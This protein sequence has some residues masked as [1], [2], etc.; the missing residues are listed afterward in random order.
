MNLKLLFRI[1]AGV[2]TVFV[3]GGVFSPQAMVESFGM[4][5]STELS[6][7]MQFAM[8]GQVF[9]IIITLQLPYWLGDNLTKA[10]MTYAGISVLPILLNVYHIVTDVLPLTSAFYIENTL[11]VAFAALF[12]MYSKKS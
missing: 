7:M 5:Y 12:Y 4:T 10:G 9:V 1:Y 2:Q 8:L 6:T 11:W 3:L